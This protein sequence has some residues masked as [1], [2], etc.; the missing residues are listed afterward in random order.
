M[1][2]VFISYRRQTAPGEAR[3]LRNDLVTR[4]G[5]D[6]VF[7]DVDSISLGRDFRSEL[8]KKLSAC[9]NMLV[10]IDKDWAAVKDEKG[11]IRL[12]KSDDFVRVEIEAALKRDIAVTPVL[13]KGAQMPAAEELPASR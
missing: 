9:D 2:T 3:A 6:A 8:Q 11:Q 4:L 7:M 10:L 5:Q 13:L 12:E 1:S